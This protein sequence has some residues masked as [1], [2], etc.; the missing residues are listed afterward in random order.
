MDRNSR[1]STSIKT[2]T[3]KTPLL[4]II[5]YEDNPERNIH[6]TIQGLNE[7]IHGK[8]R[9]SDIDDL[10]GYNPPYEGPR[11]YHPAEFE[12]CVMDETNMK[13]MAPRLLGIGFSETTSL[14]IEP[15]TDAASDMSSKLRSQVM[16]KHDGK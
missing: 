16:T 9:I 12:R 6:T 2:K 13:P 10:M 11:S 4:S 8:S 14:E 5:Q 15:S 3:K 7:I 1:Q